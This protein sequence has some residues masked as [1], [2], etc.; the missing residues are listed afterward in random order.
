[1]LKIACVDNILSKKFIMR[2]LILIII[3]T[4]DIVTECVQKFKI[5]VVLITHIRVAAPKGKMT[6][7]IFENWFKNSF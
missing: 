2:F 1:M 7:E 3:Q 4:L 6:T 5:K